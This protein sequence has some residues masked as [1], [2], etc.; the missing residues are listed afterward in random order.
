MKVLK[1]ITV[2]TLCLSGAWAGAA[3]DVHFVDPAKFSDIR[4][5]NFRRQDDALEAIQ[6]HFQQLGDKQ[7]P[8]KDLKIEIT[9]VDLAGRI[10]PRRRSPDMIRILRDT[11]DGPMIS[12]R[13]VLSENG[14]EVRHG[15]ASLR[16][17]N[18]LGGFNS[19]SSS[20]PLRYEKKMI[21]DWFRKEF[22]PSPM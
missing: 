7:F 14:V 6:A 21:D 3:V 1:L 8:G 5:Q 9:D 10:E 13:Y 16:D 4:D 15:E 18:Y 12:L 20:D 11:G 17:M 19:Y 2:L 22:G